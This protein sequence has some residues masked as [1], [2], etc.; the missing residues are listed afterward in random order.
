MAKEYT[1]KGKSVYLIE[2]DW[3][4]VSFGLRLAR[5]IQL[6]PKELEGYDEA[7][8]KLLDNLSGRYLRIAESIERQVHG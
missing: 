5:G 6:S 8:R 1:P 7:S 4:D 3:L 2:E